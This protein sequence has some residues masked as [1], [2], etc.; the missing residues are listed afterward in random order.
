M[1]TIVLI[2][3][4]VNSPYLVSRGL[5]NIGWRQLAHVMFQTEMSDIPTN[6]FI[7]AGLVNSTN[8]RAFVGA[9]IAYAE[10]L[11]ESN[12]RQYWQQ[13]LI[14]PDLLNQL[15]RQASSR[16]LQDVALIYFRGAEDLVQTPPGEGHFWAGRICQSSLNN[17]TSLSLVNQQYCQDYFTN[18]SDNLLLDGQFEQDVDRGWNGSFFFTDTSASIALDPTAGV[19]APSL[20]LTGLTPG[21]HAGVYQ[22]VSLQPGSKVHFGGYFRTE[23]LGNQGTQLLY[24]EWSQSDNIYGVHFHTINATMDWTY[25]EAIFTLPESSEPWVQFYPVLLNGQ[26]TVWSDHVTVELLPESE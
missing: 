14:E 11:D 15:G 12:A 9:G 26:G 8:Y 6:Y 5:S 19:P 24:V 3:V 2:I 20:M 7:D 23:D 4:V 10:V 25:L 16:G 1:S 13:A 21:R 22:R 18:S 17:P